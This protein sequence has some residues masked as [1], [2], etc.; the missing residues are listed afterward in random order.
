MFRVWKVEYLTNNP[1]SVWNLG[2]P[3]LLDPGNRKYQAQ[4][5][6]FP[7]FQQTIRSQRIVSEVGR[8]LHVTSIVEFFRKHTFQLQIAVLLFFA[9]LGYPLSGLMEY[10]RNWN[11]IPSCP[12]ITIA[13]CVRLLIARSVLDTE[14]RKV[15]HYRGLGSSSSIAVHSLVSRHNWY[16]NKR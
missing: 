3:N 13:N 1:L 9:F 8:R 2:F 14:M 10:R 6:T 7:R 12:L 5:Y 11:S 4:D 16:C 15:R